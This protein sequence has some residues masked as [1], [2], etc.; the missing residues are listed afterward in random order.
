MKV[1]GKNTIVGASES[2]SVQTSTE[3][4]GNGKPIVPWLQREMIPGI[5]N[6]YLLFGAGTLV[7]F[8][9]LAS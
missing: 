3:T 4:T 2:E 6:Q 5:K 9:L 7:A 1:N 8:K